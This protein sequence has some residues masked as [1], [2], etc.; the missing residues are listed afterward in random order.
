M[1]REVSLDLIY[2]VHN[3]HSLNNMLQHSRNKF[4]QIAIDI[5]HT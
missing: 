3:A 1:S 5:Y 4:T 2:P